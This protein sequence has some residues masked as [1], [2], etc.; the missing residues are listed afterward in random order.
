[1]M[2]DLLADHA[3]VTG[4]VWVRKDTNEEL[5]KECVQGLLDAFLLTSA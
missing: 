2:A 4:R 1:M 3:R 5:A